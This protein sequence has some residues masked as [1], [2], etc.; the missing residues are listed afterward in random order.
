MERSPGVMMPPRRDLGGWRDI[1]A[2]DHLFV[3]WDQAAQALAR[4]R[5]L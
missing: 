3:D 1:L 5:E 2:H 4:L